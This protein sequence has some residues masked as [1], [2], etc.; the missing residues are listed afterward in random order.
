MK[1]KIISQHDRDTRPPPWV[2]VNIAFKASEQRR[3]DR[4]RKKQERQLKIKA[5]AG[6]IQ[7][8]EADILASNPRG[9]T[10]G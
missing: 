8:I 5:R 3:M 7:K 6:A 10:V 1:P 4:I 2:R 9:V